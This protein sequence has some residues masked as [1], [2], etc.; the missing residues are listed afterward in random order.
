VVIINTLEEL[1]AI[2]LGLKNELFNLA[3]KL[4]SALLVFCIGYVIARLSKVLIIKLIHYCGKIVNKKFPNINLSSASVF[5]GTT[6]FWFTLLSTVLL[7]TDILGIPI[8]TKW[9]ESILKFSPNIFAAIFIIL[10]AAILGRVVSEVI[11]TAMSAVGFDYGKRLGTIVYYLILVTAIIIAID[12]I[13]IEI[14]F[15]IHLIIIVLGS[16]LFGT[17]LAFGLG[18]KTSVS[19]ILSSYYIRKIFQEGDYIRIDEIEGTITKIDSTVVILDSE[20]ERIV[21]PTMVFNQN[22]SFLIRRK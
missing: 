1:N 16:V 13:G 4:I 12:Q 11:S 20:T 17:A 15:L 22:K 7:I 5:I 2:F 10:I 9:L 21:I 18:A 14:N 6:F 8:V 19:N 3:P